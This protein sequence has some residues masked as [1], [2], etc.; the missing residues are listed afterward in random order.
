M[1]SSLAEFAY[2]IS[3]AAIEQQERRLGEL[4]SRTG[5]LLAAATVAASFLGAEAARSGKVGV[6]GTL[7]L[8]AY[9]ACTG[10]GLYVLLPHQLILEFQGTV[11]LELAEDNGASLEESQRIAAKWI[12]DFHETNRATLARLGRWY[13]AGCAALGIEVLLWIISLSDKL[14][15]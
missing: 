15:K 1:A 13:T 12:E 8:L 7:G 10:G 14:V 2:G 6:L 3:F 4:R 9:L 5:T 11:L